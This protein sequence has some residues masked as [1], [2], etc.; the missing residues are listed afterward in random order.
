[1]G[2]NTNEMIETLR[3]RL[4]GDD[5]HI[6]D[7]LIKNLG[8]Y[9]GD[10]AYAAFK[11]AVNDFGKNVISSSLENAWQLIFTALEDLEE[12]TINDHTPFPSQESAWTTDCRNFFSYGRLYIRNQIMDGL[13]HLIEMWPRMFR[14][15]W[16]KKDVCG[17][18]IHRCPGMYNRKRCVYK[19]SEGD[20]ITCPICGTFRRLCMASPAMNGRCRNHGGALIAQESRFGGR[21]GKYLKYINSSGLRQQFLDALENGELDLSADINLLSSRTMQLVASLGDEGG[22]LVKL[23][24]TLERRQTALFRAADNEDMERFQR[25]YR[26]LLYDL[27]VVTDD[28]SKWQ[29][30]R[31]NALTIKQLTEAQRAGLV[32]D[33]QMIT[34]DKMLELLGQT[35]TAVKQGVEGASKDVAHRFMREAQ[36]LLVHDGGYTEAEADAI[37]KFIRSVPELDEGDIIRT[38]MLRHLSE[39]FNRQRAEESKAAII[40]ALQKS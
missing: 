36:Y 16:D 24:Q 39:V 35:L 31:T 7:A 3:G 9:K 5:A 30:I 22:D 20:T 34:I 18:Q 2:A 14:D 17:A 6:F 21:A 25:L 26:D 10:F 8:H 32:Q 37:F 11:D 27:Q 1:M 38:E 23:R 12:A 40:T 29:E 33:K 4:V 13:Y 15:T 28:S 19:W